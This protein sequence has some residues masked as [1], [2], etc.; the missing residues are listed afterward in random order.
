MS[1]TDD[2]SLYRII[3]NCEDAHVKAPDAVEIRDH[4]LF[5]RN[6]RPVPFLASPNHGDAL[7]PRYLVVHYTA[8]TTLEAAVS[9]FLT[10]AAKVSAHVI[11]DRDGRS[12]QL[13]RFDRRAWHAGESRWGAYSNLNAHALGL[14]LVNAGALELSPDGEWVDWAG[15][16]L[17]DCDVLVA[18]HA[19][20]SIDRGWHVFTAVQIARAAAI[21]RALR[22]RYGL[23]AVLGH[24]Q[25]APGRKLDPGPAFPMARFAADVLGTAAT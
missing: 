22:V 25:I 17:P 18:R 2:T 24:D 23:V 20:E 14:E 21:A 6:G 12:V 11:V 3:A 7:E 15:R 9:W 13:V 19:R 8:S 1:G 5:E 4:R 10:P 16:R